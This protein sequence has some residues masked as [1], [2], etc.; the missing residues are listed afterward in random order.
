MPKLSAILLLAA[1]AL[2]AQFAAPPPTNVRDASA[3]HPP[4]GAKVAIV[5]FVDLECPVCASTNP[6]VEAAAARYKVPLVRHD[7]LIPAHAWSPIAATN[8]RWFDLTS[9]TLGDQYRDAVFAAQP[10]LYNNPDLLRAFTQQFAAQH[11][12]ALPFAIDPQGKLFAAVKADSDLGLRTGIDHTPTVFVVTAGGR[13]RPWIEV[14][15]PAADLYTVLDQAFADTGSSIPSAPATTAPTAPA[16]ASTPAQPTATPA[17][18][19]PAPTASAPASAPP[20]APATD[21]PAPPPSPLN[22]KRIA[23]ILAALIGLVFFIWLGKRK[24]T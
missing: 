9:R 8:A 12:I 19:T 1:A 14:Q 17:E 15:R 23:G 6:I 16:P 5:E 21:Q 3:L 11:N 18:T 13:G 20:A 10:T 2:H 4:P 24:S 22:L 7:F